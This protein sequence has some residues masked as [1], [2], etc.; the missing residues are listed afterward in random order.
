MDA[1]V[2]PGVDV[3]IAVPRLR[4][5]GGERRL[6]VTAQAGFVRVY[7]LEFVDEGWEGEGKEF[8]KGG[9]G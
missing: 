2:R 8:W 4:E 3:G 9:G 7:G 5:R 6:L 1:V